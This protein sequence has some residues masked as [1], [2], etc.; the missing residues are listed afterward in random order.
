VQPII[1]NNF[2][3]SH[4]GFHNGVRISASIN[5]ILLILATFLARTRLP[6][7]KTRKEFSTLRLLQEP[8]Y[9]SLLAGFVATYFRPVVMND[10]SL[11]CYSSVFA[12]LGLFYPFFYLQLNAVT[13]HV[14][15]KFAFYAVCPSVLCLACLLTIL[16]QTSILNAASVFGRWIPGLLA[17]YVGVLNIGTFTALGTGIVIFTM[18]AVRDK[19][20][21]ILF[22]IFFGLFSGSLIAST[23]AMAGTWFAENVYS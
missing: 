3:T 16:S 19:T 6:P 7:K 8:A 5:I 1:L 20:G 17:P 22:A 23:P 21:T 14:D 9:G 11:R 10:N 4:I 18:I 15:K 12:F 13:H 2:F